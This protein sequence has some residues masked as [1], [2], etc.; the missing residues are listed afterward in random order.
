MVEEER[1]AIP[2]AGGLIRSRRDGEEWILVQERDKVGAPTETGLLEIPAGK[3]R[4]FENIYDCLRREIREETGC[5]VTRIHGE[6]E[7]VRVR[8]HGYEVLSYAPYASSQNL[9]GTYPIM[10]Q[11]F[12]CDVEGP[13]AEGIERS[14]ESRHI[15]WIRRAELA[16][17]VREEPERFYPMHLTT[18]RRYLTE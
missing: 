6:D 14:D 11:T 10:V 15:R 8:M 5:A 18:L 7:A 3:V 16:R 2:G 9:E 4:A 12:L 1:F 13:L 17:L